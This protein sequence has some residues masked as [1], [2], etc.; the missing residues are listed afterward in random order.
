MKTYEEY[1]AWAVLVAAQEVEDNEFSIG[2]MLPRAVG[3]YAASFIYGISA[4]DIVQQ[5]WQR[6]EQTYGNPCKGNWSF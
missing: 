1:L 5:V 3:V 2:G 6:V 4:Y